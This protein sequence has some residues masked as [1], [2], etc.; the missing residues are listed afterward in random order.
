MIK[1]VVGVSSTFSNLE[2]SEASMKTKGKLFFLA[3]SLETSSASKGLIAK[4]LSFGIFPF[5]TDV[6]NL[7]ISTLQGPHQVAQNI[8][9]D[10]EPGGGK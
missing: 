5:S 9:M 2:T 1:I 3:N 6:F 4:I 7:S 10:F 8:A